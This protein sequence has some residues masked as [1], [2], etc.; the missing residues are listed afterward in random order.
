MKVA[1]RINTDNEL[2]LFLGVARNTISSWRSRNT[3]DHAL[4][5]SK[6]D[7]IN[8]DWLVTGRGEMLK[9]SE[10][11]FEEKRK[12]KSTENLTKYWYW[13]NGK[14]DT[15]R[16][17]FGT[18]A[19]DLRGIYTP[20]KVVSIPVVDVEAAAGGSAVNSDY[21]YDS[22]VMRLPSY[23]LPPTSAKCLCISVRGE[24]MEPTLFDGSYIVVR[25]LDRSE[26]VTIR[27]GSV[28]VVTDRKGNTYVKRLRNNLSLFSTVTLLS[29]NPD[30]KRYTPFKLSEDCL[31]SG[32]IHF[33]QHTTVAT[34][35]HR[36]FARPDE[37]T[38]GM[39]MGGGKLEK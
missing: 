13:K 28:Y 17:S 32:T 6:C 36:R 21:L 20:S 39:I 33:R 30:Q 14:Y 22:D 18:I 24:S 4:V 9:S 31:E 1:C 37:R 26:W 27:S 16:P 12:T 7:H 25:L 23:I 15:R 19:A 2:A 38:A 5:F 10:N 34:R 29:D 8:I 3:M 35:S 11:F